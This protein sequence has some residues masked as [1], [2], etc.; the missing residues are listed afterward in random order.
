MQRR[1]G[2]EHGELRGRGSP[3]S[4][5]G[6]T[7]LEGT[8]ERIVVFD[9]GVLQTLDTLGVEGVV[10][11]PEVANMPEDLSEYASDDYTKVGSLKEPDYEQVNALEPDLIIV[12]ARSAPA[13]GELSEIAPTIDMTVDT[14]N[15]LNSAIER[16]ETLGE[17]FG[18]EDEVRDRLDALTAQ[19]SMRS[20]ALLRK[21]VVS[22]V[23]SMVGGDLGLTVGGGSC[24]D[25]VRGR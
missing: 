8:P 19:R 16:I 21:L 11:V 22:T 15:F 2:S 13:Y 20:M 6:S 4:T 14:T 18:K 5:P 7:S 1:L 25:D 9:L 23:M 3:W 10:G 12:A 24:R 17:L